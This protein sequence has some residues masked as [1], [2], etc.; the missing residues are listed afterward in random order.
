MLVSGSI[1]RVFYVRNEND[2]SVSTFGREV[3]RQYEGEE[4]IETEGSV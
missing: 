2:E 4:Y 1:N 3:E